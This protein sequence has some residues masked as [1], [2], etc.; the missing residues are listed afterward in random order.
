VNIGAVL[1]PESHS[2]LRQQWIY[3]LKTSL[4]LVFNQPLYGKGN[5]HGPLVRGSVLSLRCLLLFRSIVS[6]LCS[7]GHV[8]KHQGHQGIP[9]FFPMSTHSH[10]GFTV[11]SNSQSH[12]Q[13][14]GLTQGVTLTR[15]SQV[16][17]LSSLCFSF[18]LVLVL[19]VTA[20]SIIII[21]LIERS[22]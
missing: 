12:Q 4:P 15:T 22:F 16:K 11:S 1:H 10:F 13:R 5:S 14:V 6:P 21:L 9:P 7:Q 8:C 20:L 19:I 3:I 18:I 2:H 17:V